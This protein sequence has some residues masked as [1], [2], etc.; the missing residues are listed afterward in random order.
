MNMFIPEISSKL[1]LTD[2]WCFMLYN[3]ARNL[4]LFKSLNLDSSSNKNHLIT[5]PKD[6]ILTVKRIYIK[7]SQSAYSSLTFSINK[8][9]SP[10]KRFWSANFWASLLDVNKI[11][12]KLK[13]C[14][15]ELLNDIEKSLILIKNLTIRPVD[16]RWIESILL[17]NLNINTFRSSEDSFSFFLKAYDRLDE[18]LKRMPKNT[19]MLYINLLKES[20]KIMSFNLRKYKIRKLLLTVE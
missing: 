3:E 4:K 20:M 19:G 14:N 17:D 18:I 11:Q 10:D 6:T 1:I 13:E 8:K 5:I 15:E 2:D 12:F 16:Y 9:D 7:H